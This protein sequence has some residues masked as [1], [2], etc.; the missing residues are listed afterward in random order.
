MADIRPNGRSRCRGKA[1]RCEEIGPHKKTAGR[2]GECRPTAERNEASKADRGKGSLSLFSAVS[3]PTFRSVQ[4][5]MRSRAS[6]FPSA[7]TRQSF[8][9]PRSSA[10]CTPERALLHSKPADLSAGCVPLGF[11]ASRILVKPFGFAGWEKRGR[12]QGVVTRGAA[13]LVF[14]RLGVG[15]PGAPR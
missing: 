9:T 3:R 5:E 15:G 14:S 6:Q 12:G 4:K 1:K 7:Q 8:T 10:V 13:W 11:K 2:H